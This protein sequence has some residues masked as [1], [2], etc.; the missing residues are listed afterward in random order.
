MNQAGRIADLLHRAFHGNAW[1]G[2]AVLEVLADVSAPTAA[3]RPLASAHSIWELVLHI[4]AW[5]GAVFRRL[6][7]DP[8]LLGDAEDFPPVRDVSD[9]AWKK[10]MAALGSGHEALEQAVRALPE[11]RLTEAVPGKDYDIYFLLH[12]VIQHD[13]YHAGQM[14]VL[15]KSQRKSEK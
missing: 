13:L 4:T 8:A 7:G 5:E 12:G 11:S 10:V 15:K 1:H 9:A 2:P 14:A 3:A 6:D